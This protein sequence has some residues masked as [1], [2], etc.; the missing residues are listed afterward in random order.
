MA[1]KSKPKLKMPKEF[2]VTTIAYYGYA[3]KEDALGILRTN[4]AK[5]VAGDCETR[6]NS[7][8][9]ITLDGHIWK[10]RADAAKEG[11]KRGLADYKGLV[12][13]AHVKVTLEVL[14]K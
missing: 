12:D 13:L 7:A 1:Q 2:V 10:N 9:M 4:R 14:S 5:E 6:D 8:Q 11:L 3:F